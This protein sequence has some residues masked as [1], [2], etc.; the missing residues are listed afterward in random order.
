MKQWTRD[1]QNPEKFENWMRQYIQIIV[2]GWVFYM[3]RQ[4]VILFLMY[5]TLI[6]FK[7]SKK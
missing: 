3:K 5:L 4:K 6:F 1:I 7:K 2:Y